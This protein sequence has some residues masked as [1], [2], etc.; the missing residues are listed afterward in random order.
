MLDSVNNFM[1]ELL[2]Y[3]IIVGALP[4]VLIANYLTLA[5]FFGQFY[6][7][8]NERS[9]RK[10]KQLKGRYVRW[11]FDN[12]TMIGNT[13]LIPNQVHRPQS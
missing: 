1:N 10:K 8:W 3:F 7:D 9:K 13:D 2:R 5:F 6:E 11:N 12:I 4:A